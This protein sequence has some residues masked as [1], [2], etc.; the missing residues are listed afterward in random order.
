MSTLVQRRKTKKK[1]YNARKK[2]RLEKY[3]SVFETE[4]NP[5]KTAREL[6][7][8]EPEPKV[9]FEVIEEEEPLEKS[10]CVIT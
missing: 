8:I 2:Q 9:E 1:R 10:Y 7:P 6:P 5:P 4:N 3:T